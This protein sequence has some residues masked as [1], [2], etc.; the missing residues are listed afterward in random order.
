MDSPDR[1]LSRYNER[2]PQTEQLLPLEP[3]RWRSSL[4]VHSGRSP[5]GLQCARVQGAGP[6]SVTPGE[7]SGR[8]AV[9]ERVIASL[10]PFFQ[11]WTHGRLPRYARRRMDTGDI[12]QEAIVGVLR[13]LGEIDTSDP[14]ALR[15]YLVIA[16]RNRI[17]DEVRRA[18]H[19]EV[20]NGIRDRADARRLTARGGD[21]LREPTAVSRGAADPRGGRSDAAGRAHRAGA[22]VRRAGAGHQAAFGRCRTHRDAARGAASRPRHGSRGIRLAT[23]SGSGLR[24]RRPAPARGTRC[25]GSRGR[26]SPS[27][28]ARC[29]AASGDGG[30]PGCGARAS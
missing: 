9:V 25:R 8:F 19:G 16:I 28:S 7:P 5:G 20:T 23:R 2:P 6:A 1:F 12:V 24:A 27:G 18:S 17:S 11:R 26:R 29:R 14:E 10:L 3:R 13:N 15:K 21:R 4:G 30:G 22:V